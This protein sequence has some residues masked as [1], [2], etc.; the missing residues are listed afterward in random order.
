M[1]TA[2]CL[3]VDL[4]LNLPD[5]FLIATSMSQV[6]PRFLSFTTKSAICYDEKPLHRSHM[7]IME[8][9]VEDPRTLSM[10][11]KHKA[12]IH[13][14]FIVKR[15]NV[16]AEA[17]NNYGNRSRGSGYSR[18]SIHAERNVIKE[19]GDIR[20][21]RGADMYIMRFARDSSLV[22]I[23]RIVNSEPCKSCQVFLEK[24]IREYGLRNVYFTAQL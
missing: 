8:Q 14:A 12:M 22:G 13:R 6:T 21:L 16:I 1:E 7:S 11:Q 19:L 20:L 23:E 4:N 2:D 17:S 18:S 3:S 5:P 15:G 9:F 10:C 24:C